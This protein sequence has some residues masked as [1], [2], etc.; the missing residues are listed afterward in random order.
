[1]PE[2]GY[3]DAYADDR[4]DAQQPTHQRDDYLVRVPRSEIR[5]LQRKAKALDALREAGVLDEI[6]GQAPPPD[7]TPLEPGEADF[8]RERGQLAADAPPDRFQ[9][10]DPY[11]EAQQVHDRVIAEGGREREALGSAFNS[12]ANAAHRGDQRVILKNPRG[13]SER[14]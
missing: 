6:A 5:G 11:R 2:T 9:G 1:M 7:D 3:D 10:A 4:Y 13:L 14:S 12:I 8:T